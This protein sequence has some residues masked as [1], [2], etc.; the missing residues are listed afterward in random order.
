MFYVKEE[1]NDA[2][3][4]TIEITDENVYGTCPVCG[5]EVPIDLTEVFSD[6]ATDLF[7]TS[8]LCDSCAKHVLRKDA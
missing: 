3:D 8:V 1:L 2:M 7:A 5:K 4:I 6:S